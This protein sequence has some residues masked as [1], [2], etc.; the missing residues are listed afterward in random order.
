M[1]VP[2]KQIATPPLAVN[3]AVA[4]VINAAQQQ[5]PE[6]WHGHHHNRRRSPAQHN[7]HTVAARVMTERRRRLIEGERARASAADDCDS[8][9]ITTSL[10][11]RQA[12]AAIRRSTVWV[13]EAP[14]CGFGCRRNSCKHAFDAI[15]VV[16]ASRAQIEDTI[17]HLSC[18]R[19]ERRARR[20]KGRARCPFCADQDDRCPVCIVSLSH[21]Y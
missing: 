10:S 7:D 17:D 5:Q 16:A 8:F 3:A 18:R 4:P 12:L 1:C 21:V 11:G 2:A 13:R 9:V 6:P 20:V 19:L 14:K 15:D